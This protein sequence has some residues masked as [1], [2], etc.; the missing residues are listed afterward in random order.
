M[1]VAETFALI[2]GSLSLIPPTISIIEKLRDDNSKEVS[3]TRLVNTFSD[4]TLDAVKELHKNIDQIEK[5]LTS[6]GFDLEK[7]IRENDEDTRWSL[8]KQF[9][10]NSSSRKISKIQENLRASVNDIGK[11][12]MC[13]GEFEKMKDF[14]DFVNAVNADLDNIHSRP[15]G[16]ILGIYRSWLINYQKKLS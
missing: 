11:V 2:K 1:P 3:M 6:I 14:E 5:S 12:L 8:E 16:E 9:V 15:I 4:D 7:S 10:V 13:R